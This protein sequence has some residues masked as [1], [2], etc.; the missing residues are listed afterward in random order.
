MQILSVSGNGFECVADGVTKVEDGAQAALGFILADHARFNLTTTCDHFAERLGI[1]LEHF[2]QVAFESGK[3]V[4]IVDDSVF[5]HF[6]ESG[7]E[8]AGWERLQ[9]VQIA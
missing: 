3:Q 6:R 7:A 2:G 9:R 1:E 8:F 4:R 5:D